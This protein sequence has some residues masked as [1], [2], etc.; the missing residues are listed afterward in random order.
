[1]KI[2]IH[3]RHGQCQAHDGA[4][5]PVC[6]DPEVKR[7]GLALGVH[8][9]GFLWDRDD[10]THRKRLESQTDEDA[11]VKTQPD[12]NSRHRELIIGFLKLAE[13]SPLSCST[14]GPSNLSTSCPPDCVTLANQASLKRSCFYSAVTFTYGFG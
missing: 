2:G 9:E 10:W 14:D 11:G 8:V 5:G 12:F 1:M 13:N 4:P 3:S 6:P 7:V